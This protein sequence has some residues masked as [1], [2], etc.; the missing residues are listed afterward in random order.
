MSWL[1]DDEWE[2]RLGIVNYLIH[3]KNSG[4]VMFWNHTMKILWWTRQGPDNHSHSQITIEH[5]IR[6]GR[7]YLVE[8]S[9]YKGH[10]KLPSRL[11]GGPFHETCCWT[12]QVQLHVSLSD[13]RLILCGDSNQVSDLKRA[14]QDEQ[15]EDC[16]SKRHADAVYYQSSWARNEW[17]A[18]ENNEGDNCAAYSN[19][20]F[21]TRSRDQ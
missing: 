20:T 19:T 9:W 12:F 11:I 2:S 1:R 13:S 3:E 15:W 21:Q 5:H 4:S 7:T 8:S 18:F 6:V 17:Q 10:L 16:R 14:C